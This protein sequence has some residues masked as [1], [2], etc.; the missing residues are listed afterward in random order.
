MRQLEAI[1]RLSESISK[2]RLCNVV[3]KNDVEEAH[4]LFNVRLVYINWLDFDYECNQKWRW[5]WI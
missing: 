1:I 4:R 3:V 5:Y 2:M